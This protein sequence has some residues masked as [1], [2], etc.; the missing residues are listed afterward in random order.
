MTRL[1][2]NPLPWFAHLVRVSQT[3]TILHF[4]DIVVKVDT[5]TGVASS[6]LPT[7]LETY[8]RVQWAFS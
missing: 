1:T 2:S 6:A 8:Y 5:D 7:L 4:T 3:L